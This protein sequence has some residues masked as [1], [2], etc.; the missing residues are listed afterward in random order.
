MSL[1]KVWTYGRTKLAKNVFKKTKELNPFFVFQIGFYAI[2]TNVC[3]RFRDGNHRVTFKK[4]EY[5]IMFN[6]KKSYFV[7]TFFAAQMA[8]IEDATH[9]VIG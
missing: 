8:F 7:K 3:L 1:T 5:Q 2:C 6:N 9:F 4:L